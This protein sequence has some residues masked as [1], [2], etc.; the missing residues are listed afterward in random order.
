MPLFHPNLIEQ[1][2]SSKLIVVDTETTGF[3]DNDKIIDLAW[4]RFRFDEQG[5][6]RDVRK[7]K[8]LVNP[9]CGIPGFITK[10]TGIEQSDVSGLP[11]FGL[12]KCQQNLYQELNGSIFIA[13]NVEFDWRMLCNEWANAGLMPPRIK[14]QI[15]TLELAKIIW[16]KFVSNKLAE[17]LRRC[18][19]D[20]DARAHR[21]SPDCVNTAK[22]FVKMYRR[23]RHYE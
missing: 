11:V 23:R 9:E 6:I 7:E 15:C 10:L 19:I 16:P 2:Q 21:A 3:S 12:N 1:I 8:S 17:V 20:S 22:A 18:N 14:N 13:H 5:A 4:L